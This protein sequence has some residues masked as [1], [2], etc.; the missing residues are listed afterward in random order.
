MRSIAVLV[1]SCPCAMGLAT[2]TAVMVGIGRAAKNG[3]LIKGGSTLELFAKIKTIVFDKTGTLT[4]GNFK[5]STINYFNNISE[6][7]AKEIIVALEMY[8]S[9]PLAKSIV[10]ELKYVKINIKLVSVKEEKGVGVTGMDENG[11]E[12]KAGSQLIAKHLNLLSQHSVYVF[13]NDKL[14]ATIDLEDELK[15][16]IKPTIDYFKSLEINPIM[17]S[18]DTASK[19]Q[20][21]ADKIGIQTVYSQ[22]LPKQKLAIVEKLSNEDDLAMV[23]DGINDAPALAK[24][25]VSISMSNA[26]EVAKQSA[27]IILLKSKNFGLLCDAHLISKHT[28]KTIKQNLFWAFFYNVVAIPIAAIGLLSPMVAALSMAFSDV[29]VIGNSIRLKTKKLS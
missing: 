15:D 27:Q 16:E 3:I 4:T 13:K 19:C 12:F 21:V 25:T 28:L 7:N 22:Q 2:P 29:I 24:A 8:S 23:G 14:I 18:G 6:E 17:L 5:I 10:A 20:A 9:H 1:I 11:N 26:T